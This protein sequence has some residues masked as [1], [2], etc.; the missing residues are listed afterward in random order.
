[1]KKPIFILSFLFLFSPILFAADE[2]VFVQVR[3]KEKVDVK[4]QMIEYSDALYFLP[5]DYEKLDQKDIDSLKQG[6]I[7]NWKYQIENPP[8]V[9]EPTKAELQ[10]QLIS[11][12]DQKTSLNVQKAE[13]LAKLAVMEGQIGE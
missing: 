9:V 12:E 11:I 4:G 6:R 2:E 5:E 13:I 8:P 3:F 10:A 7:D 1:M